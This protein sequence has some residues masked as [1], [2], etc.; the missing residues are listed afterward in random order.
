MSDRPA[1]DAKPGAYTVLAAEHRLIERG[2]DLL[3]RL[4]RKARLTKTLDESVANGLLGFFR[5]FADLTHHL[6]EERILF[7][8]IDAKGFFP[9]CGL[10]S[11]HELGRTRLRAMA[12]VVERAARGDDE[13]RK[14][15]LRQAGSY[16][17]LLRAHIAKEDEC[18]ANVCARTFDSEDVARLATAYEDLERREVGKGAFERFTVA[19]EALEARL[20]ADGLRQP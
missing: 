7:P 18:L 16:I 12:A 15:F 5:E 14:T 6:K 4:C 20:G 1:T 13:A 17:S 19:L 9:G 8:A 10:V 11:E 3:D 2:L